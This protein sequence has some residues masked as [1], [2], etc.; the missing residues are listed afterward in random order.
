MTILEKRVNLVVAFSKK[1]QFFK[2]RLFSTKPIIYLKTDALAP[3]ETASFCDGVRH[4][5]YSGQ[6]ERAPSFDYA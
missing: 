6:R 1:N 5:R 3:M 2:K 4:K